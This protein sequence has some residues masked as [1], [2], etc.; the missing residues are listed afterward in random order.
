MKEATMN[1]APL[2]GIT[3][4]DFTRLI[5][6]PCATDLLASLGA[7]VVK[8][9]S[10]G[11]DPM[12]FMRSRDAGAGPSSPTFNA[13]NT[14]K[15]SIV[16]DLKDEADRKVALAL[17]QRAD[18]VV[19]TFR[20]GVMDR[21]GLGAEA[22]RKI[23]PNV[24]YASLSA[25]ASGGSMAS[26]GGVDIVMQAES[27]L[28]SVTGEADG[29]PMKVGVPIVD[30]AA[31]YVLALGIVASL[32]GRE[33][34]GAGDD[35]TVS[36]MDVGIHVQAQT[37]AEFLASGQVPV[38]VGNCAPY[39]APADVYATAKGELVLSAHLPEHWRRLCQLLE[40]P[41]MFDD[42]RFVD[43]EHRVENRS[44]LNRLLTTA[45]EK[46]TA[47]EWVRILSAEGLTAGEIRDYEEV[48]TSSEVIEQQSIVDGLNIDESSLRV[49]R[50]PLRFTNW[51]DQLLVRK[52]PRL[53]EHGDDIREYSRDWA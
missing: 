20:P 41:T 11:G 50:S 27:G 51:S 1:N 36:M 3:V 7:R 15:E 37:M 46:R 9:E 13:Y 49:V 12:R 16:L 44:E 38:R 17:C 29:Y 22:I 34:H 4:I 2:D 32:L 26:R 10:E 8:V 28:M 53:N 39:A 33:R 25:F 6:G 35:V 30:A 21:L 24:V 19:E 47:S 52:V 45:L 14:L 23:N 43:T 18:A 48:V 40:V 5:A 42:P 31:G